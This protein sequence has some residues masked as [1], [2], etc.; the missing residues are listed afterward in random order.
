MFCQSNPFSAWE[1]VAPYSVVRGSSVFLV[2]YVSE[3]TII[4]RNNA[5][6]SLGVIAC[7][8]LLSLNQSP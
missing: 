7:Y 2:G 6:L 8:G 1:H 3:S 5:E 4:K